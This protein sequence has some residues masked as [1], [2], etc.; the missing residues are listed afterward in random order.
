MRVV[1][2]ILINAVAYERSEQLNQV[3][4]G[5][6]CKISFND[7]IGNKY[8]QT[9]M[10]NTYSFHTLWITNYVIICSEIF[11]FVTDLGITCVLR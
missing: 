10:F 7:V 6:L 3:T 5:D 1:I 2:M 9:H 11:I 4:K 8:L